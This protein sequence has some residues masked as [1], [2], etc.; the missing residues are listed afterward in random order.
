MIGSVDWL[1]RLWPDQLDIT[2]LAAAPMLSSMAAASRLLIGAGLFLGLIL[3]VWRVSQAGNLNGGMASSAIVLAA[4]GFG[5]SKTS[6]EVSGQRVEMLEAQAMP[7]RISMGLYRAVIPPLSAALQL[8]TDAGRVLAS[9]AALTAMADRAADAFGASDLAKQLRDYSA[10]CSPRNGELRH[11]P[12]EAWQ[13][14]GL[15]GGMLGVPDETLT[16]SVVS[17][18]FEFWKTGITLENVPL[19]EAV[20]QA[21]NY[22]NAGAARSNREQ[23]RE[24]LAQINRTYTAGPYQIA[25][26]E[27]WRGVLTGSGDASLVRIGD[28]PADLA[29]QMRTNHRTIY[30]NPAQLEAVTAM[31]PRDCVQAYWLAQY[32]AEQAYGAYLAAGRIGADESGEHVYTSSTVGAIAAH[33]RMMKN[34]MAGGGG[35]DPIEEVAAGG[36][37]ALQAAKNLL[38]MADFF[39]L[40]PALVTGSVMLLV[41]LTTLTPLALALSAF[42]GPEMLGTWAGLLAMPVMVVIVLH[43]LTLLHTVLDVIY[44]SS[45]AMLAAH[46]LPSTMHE[47][48]AGRSALAFAPGVMLGLVVLIAG[49][50]LGVSLNEFRGQAK[51]AVAGASGLITS[52]VGFGAGF[53][54]MSTGVISSSKKKEA[55]QATQGGGGGGGGDG[56]TANGGVRP[57]PSPLGAGQIANFNSRGVR[58]SMPSRPEAPK[59]QSA[60]AGTQT[61]NLNPESRSARR[62][63][64]SERASAARSSSTDAP[65]PVDAT[66]EIIERR[67]QQRDKLEG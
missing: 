22:V 19:F 67:R 27:N 60:A 3:M 40:A 57:P 51:S 18:Y 29:E 11:V 63:P 38:A 43:V 44:A 36:L 26:A 10:H 47:L 32:A 53:L 56:G 58:M 12:E 50:L 2:I 17:R 1:V 16:K 7:L 45:Q 64:R 59:G 48:D 34:S 66:Q 31:Q 35:A 46:W 65:Q 37:T 24:A 25:T 4:L 28:L 23:G 13:A 62:T 8:D 49:R 9:E 14:V 42:R 30:R 6:I 20:R 41:V 33:Y 54:A 5:M 55:T 39:A 61:I 52:A 21:Q 15:R